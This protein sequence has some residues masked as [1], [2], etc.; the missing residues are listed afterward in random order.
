MSTKLG[1][2][3]VAPLD[4]YLAAG[5]LQDDFVV[6]CTD[7]TQCIHFAAASNVRMTSA[8]AGLTINGYVSASTYCNVPDPAN[9]TS[10]SNIVYGNSNAVW[11]KLTSASNCAYGTSNALPG[12]ATTGALSTT[13]TTAT[14][15]SNV[16]VAASNQ[17]F[18]VVS[19][20]VTLAYSSNVA[21]GVTN[22]DLPGLSGNYLL[23]LSFVRPGT[24]NA[25]LRMFC[26]SNNGSTY[27]S[28]GYASGVWTQPYNGMVV[29]NAN[30]TTQVNLSTAVGDHLDG[31]YTLYNLNGSGY[32]RVTGSSVCWN[33][34]I[35]TDAR[36]TGQ[37][38]TLTN[39][40]RLN[41]SS[42]TWAGGTVKLYSLG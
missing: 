42:G 16:A 27:A 30:S 17:A 9:L 41:W 39:A 21:S 26:S 3:E 2:L 38:I 25:S 40:L 28:S 8:P 5:V 14:W 24:A 7:A 31:T 19:P 1:V 13:T 23:V 11:P 32:C 18:T 10:L 12:Y 33:G 37:G 35:V 34:T 20:A 36:A 4:G 22:V 15:G 6:R 29:T